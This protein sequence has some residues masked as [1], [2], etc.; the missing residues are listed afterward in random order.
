MR[1]KSGTRVPCVFSLFLLLLASP[2][3]ASF[4]FMRIVQVYGG[5]ASHPDA[6]YVLLQMCAEGQNHVAGTD[7]HFHDATG[8][9]IGLPATFEGDVPI[10]TNQSTILLATSNA[11]AIFG[12]AADQLMP[13]KLL[14]DG[15]KICFEGLDLLVDCFGWGAYAALPDATIGTPFDV[16]NGLPDGDAAKRDI[17]AGGPTVLD[18]IADDTNQSAADF[19]AGAPA[20]RN[21]AG[22][23]G[24]LDPDLLLIH[25]F[26]TGST[27]GW[28]FI[29][30]GD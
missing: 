19:D 29:E 13:A 28:D 22:V 23:T 10:S 16:A 25:S 26:D 7:L 12:V 21:N 9:E 6:Q 15:G 8:A 11:Q 24:A 20:P 14:V 17:S 5:G 2:A 30:S 18:C 4:H 3:I 27:V 1:A